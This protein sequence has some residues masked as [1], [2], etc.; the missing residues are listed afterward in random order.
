[1]CFPDKPPEEIEAVALE[2]FRRIGEN[3]TC[4]VRTASMTPDQIR[5][6]LSFHVPQLTGTAAPH[7]VVVAIGHFG[8][9]EL[10]AR[11]GQF[12]GGYQCATTYRGLR[13][14]YFNRVLQWLREKS[15]CRFYE[16]RSEAA[17]LKHFMRQPNAILGLLCDQHA[18]S[19]GIPLPFLGHECS[20]SAAPALFSLRYQCRLLTGFCFRTGLAQWRIEAGPEIATEEN[21]K[22]R[23]IPDIL[24]DVNH[25]FEQAVLRDPANWFWVHNRWKL[26]YRKPATRPRVLSASRRARVVKRSAESG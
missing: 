19:N 3:F 4:A 26:K 25:A 10:Y 14:P 22:A 17:E 23:A 12:L 21:G 8:N 1:M 15:G 2:N 11:F 5:R 13:Q 24:K 16:R 9:F 18:G 7:R 20:T 6:H